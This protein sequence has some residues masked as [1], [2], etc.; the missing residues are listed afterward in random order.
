MD[1]RLRHHPHQVPAKIFLSGALAAQT[2]ITSL[3]IYFDD[4]ES[5]GA[6]V[7]AAIRGRDI[8]AGFI[9]EAAMPSPSS[10]GQTE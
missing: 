5:A 3:L 10:K 7:S 4:E 9:A 1:D 6:F 2:G 8:S